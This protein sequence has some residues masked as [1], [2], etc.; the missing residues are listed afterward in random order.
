LASVVSDLRDELDNQ[1]IPFEDV[2]GQ[3]RPRLIVR[4][5]GQA[6]GLY[7]MS[8]V[9]KENEDWV[10]LASAATAA[11]ESERGF[12]IV[13]V[14]A[15]DQKPPGRV[16]KTADASRVAVLWLVQGVLH[17]APWVAANAA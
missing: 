16:L 9:P 11:L 6:Y 14:L 15:L 2:S 5:G 1:G 13:P 8:G 3:Q 7:V 10:K 12:P 4:L 17:N